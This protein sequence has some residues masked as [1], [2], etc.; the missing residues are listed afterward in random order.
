M[1]QP[2][3]SQPSSSSVSWAPLESCVRAQGQWRMQARLAAELTARLGRPQAARRA[4]GAAP[5]GRRNG[6][7]QPR[8]LRLR[9]G[10]RM[11]RRPRVRGWGERVVRRGLP[12]L[13]RRTRQGGAV[14]AQLYLQGWDMGDF[15]LARRGLLGA[16]APL[17]AASR[18]RLQARGRWEDAAWK[19]R[20]RADL[21]VG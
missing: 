13:Q 2:R 15:E 19:Q 18:A 9:L 14:L 20:R 8:R 17:S 10:T 1:T 11:V 7:G 21:A 12:W 3:T 16:G 4:A 6:D 5:Q